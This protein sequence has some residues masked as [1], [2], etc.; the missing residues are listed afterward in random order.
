MKHFEICNVVNITDPVRAIISASIVIYKVL[1]MYSY[2]SNS[3]NNDIIPIIKCQETET[4]KVQKHAQSSYIKSQ[5]WNK[6][7][8]TLPKN[9]FFRSVFLEIEDA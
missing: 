2:L 6:I 5:N 8:L 9:L 1:F 4:N 7:I 3:H